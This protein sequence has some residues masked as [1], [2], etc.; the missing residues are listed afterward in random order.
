MLVQQYLT[1][2]S[3]P[4]VFDLV[5]IH[6]RGRQKAKGRVSETAPAQT[7]TLACRELASYFAQFHPVQS[8][9]TLSA[10][11]PSG[12]VT[13]FLFLPL[14]VSWLGSPGLL[15]AHKHLQCNLLHSSGL[16]AERCIYKK[17]LHPPTNTH[18]HIYIFPLIP[19]VGLWGSFT[20]ADYDLPP[21]LKGRGMIL[22]AAD[23]FCNC[24]TCG[25]LRTF[26]RACKC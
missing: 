8:R 13:V 10:C 3:L 18:T 19:G 25:M 5:H 15:Q 9:N 24:V 14:R 2:S 16:Q 1:L 4:E 21:A 12:Q 22:P 23:S 7:P 17:A 6:C 11:P 26:Q 20:A